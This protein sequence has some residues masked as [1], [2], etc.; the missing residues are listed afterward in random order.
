MS[1]APFWADPRVLALNRRQSHTPLHSWRCRE[2]A[3]QHLLQQPSL[4]QHA[5]RTSDSQQ[6]LSGCSWQFKLVDNPSAVPSGFHEPGF[7]ASS[8]TQVRGG[9]DMRVWAMHVATSAAHTVDWLDNRAA[10]VLQIP[11]PG[12]WEC[13]GH[14]T[15]I[16][17]NFAYPILL[18]PPHVPADN[19][20]GC[21]RHTFDVPHLSSSNR[22][23]DGCSSTR[24]SKMAVLLA[25]TGVLW[26]AAAEL[27]RPPAP[28]ACAQ[29]LSAAGRR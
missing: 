24:C 19:P 17:T 14:G 9:A 2:T 11:V 12:N 25:S 21:Y 22:S 3:L 29:V 5:P 26:A 8:F 23:A 10:R 13:L 20:T 27:P 15:P 7:D 18:D 16:Y 1:A 6:L 4:Q 28:P